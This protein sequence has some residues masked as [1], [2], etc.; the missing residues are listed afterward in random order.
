MNAT[1]VPAATVV[2]GA[3]DVVLL[4]GGLAGLCLALQLRQANPQARILVLDRRRGPAPIGV[5]TVGESTVEIGAHYF[6]E[7]LGL[8]EHLRTEQL[9][10]FGFRFFHLDGRED[11]G[12]V[13]EIGVSRYLNVTSFQIDRG[14]FEN[15]LRERVRA[16]GVEVREGCTVTG[17][18]IARGPQQAPP[19]HVVRC[20][21]PQGAQE[22]QA[23]WVIDASGRAGLLKRELGLAE[24]SPHDAHSAWF[25]TPFRIDIEDWSS[26]PHWLA[27]CEQS[28]R[29]LSTNHLV[30]EGYWVWLIPLSSGYHSVGI[31]ADPAMHPPGQFSSY[32]GALAW[33]DRHQPRL[34]RALRAGGEPPGDYVAMRRFAHGCRELFSADR[35]AI[36]GEAGVFL[37]PFYSPGSDFIA[38][39][40]AYIA[41]LVTHDL[42]GEPWTPYVGI[43]GQLFRS[44]YESTLQLYVGQYKVFGHPQAL[45]TKVIWDYTYYWGVLCQLFFQDRLTDIAALGRSREP[46]ARSRALNEAMQPWLRR[47]TESV[48]AS[49]PAVLLDQAGLPWFADLNRSLVDKLDD[50]G[51]RVRIQDSLA[52]MEE[53]AAEIAGR[54][55]VQLPGC[56]DWPETRSLL[57]AAR[58]APAPAGTLLDYPVVAGR[59]AA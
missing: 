27:R 43:Y 3:W 53:L 7:V 59:D 11:I 17:L 46:L 52:R 35:W 1:A 18:A 49:N 30:G 31:V 21:S 8:G 19:A 13:Q 9:R 54:A 14:L 12:G 42:R 55:L 40:N 50:E 23:R 6:S 57:Q 15:H 38:I 24:P 28:Q 41:N 47:W 34:A 51:F 5:H 29:W 2:P 4:G 56:A 25:R 20:Q 45:A 58:R 48:P 32:E 37:D 39:A 22:L 36:T 33:L 26:D 10:K 16:L 44:F